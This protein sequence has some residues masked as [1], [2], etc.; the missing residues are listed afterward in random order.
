MMRHWIR[1]ETDSRQA[2]VAGRL[3]HDSRRTAV[4]NLERASVPRSWAMPLTGHKTEAV[5]RRYAIV[6]E[7]D[8]FEAGRRLTA[9]RTQT[10]THAAVGDISTAG[11]EARRR[12]AETVARHRASSRSIG[13]HEEP[14]LSCI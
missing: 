1:F 2:G 4:W 12:G 10:R 11:G 14:V 5:Y 6:S 3:F 7:A 8:L 13:F 9:Q